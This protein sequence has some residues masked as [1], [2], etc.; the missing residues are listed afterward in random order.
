MTNMGYIPQGETPFE[1]HVDNT[2]RQ[3]LSNCARDGYEPEEIDLVVRVTDLSD[4]QVEIVRGKI[5][6]AGLG[7]VALVDEQ[8][9]A[10]PGTVT[11]SSISPGATAL[12]DQVSA[13]RRDGDAAQ[14]RR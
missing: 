6:A 4:W 9:P 12:M 8:K 10:R 7:R 14:H 13:M 3:L 11:G 2:V 1:A 5:R